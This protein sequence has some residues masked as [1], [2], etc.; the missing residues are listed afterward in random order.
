[1][2]AGFT[3][4]AIIIALLSPRPG[5]VCVPAI[6]AYSELHI[7]RAETRGFVEQI[8][9]A[10]GQQVTAGTLLVTLRG[11]DVR[12]ELR[13]VELQ[14]E[15]SELK[16]RSMNGEKEIA[17]AQAEL[18]RL[19]A[20]S[21]RRDQLRRQVAQLEIRA[22]DEAVVLDSHLDHLLGTFI[23]VGQPVIHMA[24]ES[25]KEVQVSI[26]ETAYDAFAKQIGVTPKVHIRG[27]SRAI[28]A[29]VLAKVEPKANTH[30]RHDAWAAPYGG[31]LPVRAS[32]HSGDEGADSEFRLVAPRFHGVIALPPEMAQQ[33]RD[34]QV[35]EVKLDDAHETVGQWA[36][37]IAANWAY[38]K[39]HARGGE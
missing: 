4:G 27:V 6:V 2:I 10:E 17:A 7:V 25:Q 36:Y 33:L 28:D 35:G 23:E 31:P 26:P 11:D 1:V 32:S 12:A 19:G 30:L 13:D 22:P 29:G 38:G 21:E 5:G 24:V 14:W 16:A 20:L 39:H 8:H 34:G 15:Q 9:V 37:R 3:L 18:E